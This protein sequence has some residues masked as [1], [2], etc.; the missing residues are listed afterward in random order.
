MTERI[1]VEIV[2]AEPERYWR[3]TMQLTQGATVQDALDAIDRSLFPSDM[4]VDSARIA[5][6]GSVAKP[7]NALYEN[8][9]IE[10]LRPLSR[11]PKD[12][13]RLRAAANLS[14][15]PVSNW[16]LSFSEDALAI[17]GAVLTALLPVVVLFVVVVFLLLFFWIMPK[18]FRRLRRVTLWFRSF[19]SN[20][21]PAG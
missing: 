12:T 1:T 5:V 3:Q 17:G 11:D 10:L 21:Q 20:P 2:Y 6:F 7:E 15:E 4:A 19:I 13:R 14:P 8:D 9:R 18:V 16:A